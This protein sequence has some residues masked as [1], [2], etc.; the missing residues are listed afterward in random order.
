MSNLAGGGSNERDALYPPA[1]LISDGRL[2]SNQ[3]VAFAHR[4]LS[5]APSGQPPGSFSTELKS[6]VTPRTAG[7]R[8]DGSIVGGFDFADEDGRIVSE[9]RQADFRERINKEQK[10]KIGS[11]NLLEALVSKSA[12]QTKEQRSKV[13]S[14][15]NSSNRKI[16]QLRLQLEEEIERSKGPSTPSRNRLSG[17]FRPNVSRSPTH[18]QIAPS[19]DPAAETETESP[20]LVLA[21]ILQ[22]LETQGMQPDYYVERANSLVELFKRHATLKYDL[23]WSIF[24]LR[25]QTMLL[26]DSREVVAAGY[27]VTR[28]AITDRKSLN[29]M[30]GL[31][32]DYLVVLSLVKEG[33]ASVEREQALKFVRA[34]IDV[35]EGVKEISRAVVRT[36]VSVAENNEDRLKSMCILTL[37]EILIRD[38][39]LL[40][41]AGGVG[42][43]TEAL[44]DGTYA[45]SESLVAAF[46]YLLDMPSTRKYLSSGHELEIIFSSFTDPLSTEGQE[47]KLKANAKVIASIL[48]TWPGLMALS[49]QDFTAITS[50]LSSLYF[51]NPSM[52]DLILEL[53]FEILRIKPPSWSSSFLAGRRLTTYGRVASLKTETPTN[54]ITQHSEDGSSQRSLVDHFTALLLAVLIKSGLLKALLYILQNTEDGALKRKAT[55]LL[56]EVLK[57]ANALLPSD[58]SADLQA[59]PVLFLSASNFSAEHRFLATNAVYQVDSVNRTLYRSSST[60]ALP[61]IKPIEESEQIGQ[62]RETDQAKAKANALVD[63]AQFRSLLLESQVL[64]SINHTK[65]KWDLIQ[66]IIEGPLLNPKRLDEAIKATKFVKRLVGFYRPFKYRFSDIRN[67]K[68][69]RRYVK[70]GCAL[71]STLLQNPEGVKY[72]AENKLLR[73]IA[74]CLAQLDRMSG[75]TSPSPLF[76]RSRLSETLTGGYF[77]ILGVL[78]SDPKGLLM[79][80]RWRMINMFY[81]IIEL[82]DRDD[83]VKTLLSNMDFALY[84]KSPEPYP[85]FL[86]GSSHSHLRVMLSKALT[87]CPKSIRIHATRLLRKYAVGDIQKAQKTGTGAANAEWAIRLLVTQ[88]YDPEVEVC[89]VAVKILEESCNRKHSLEYVVRCRP[90]LDHLGEIGAPLL[91]RPNEA[92]ENSFLSTSLG[93]HYL[94]GLDYISQEMDDWFLGRNDTYVSLVE[95]SLARAL[96]EQAAKP[97]HS[98]DEA[99][100]RQDYG[101]VPPH[102]YRELTRTAEGCRLLEEKGHFD[103]FVFTIREYGMEQNDAELILKV[104]GCLWA[105]GNVGSMPLSAPFLEKTDVVKW[106]VKIAEES[107]I[108]SMRGTAFYVL[109]LISRSLHGLEILTECGWDVRTTTLGESLG[110]CLPLDLNRLLV[111]KEA[112]IAAGELYDESRTIDTNMVITD[113]DV[114]N[115]KILELVVNLGNTVLTK[116]AAGELLQIKAKKA[117]GFQQPQLFRKVMRILECH[118]FRLQVQRFV[119][120]LFDKSVLRKIVLE[121]EDSED[122]Q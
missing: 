96:T 18:V 31:H 104:K 60:A 40:V 51:P 23:V 39:S 11:E 87:A 19:L 58:W 29:I 34:F 7:L 57:L 6:T 120:D 85:T 30:R 22:A 2:Q 117:V 100:E 35:K 17:L 8:V 45:A 121:E 74:E 76:S 64:N 77:A 16:A 93:Y 69:N 94:D 99:P 102:F 81:H 71:I 116:R 62:T 113:K 26:S 103:D 9:Q 107:E 10:I 109:G 112:R 118:H 65:W 63:E 33:K 79:I 90:A 115:A 48:K 50:L 27:R 21:E 88:L 67:T 98:A 25:M 54:T 122:E 111:V 44:A 3:S 97:R 72:L 47:Q 52:R 82:K 46:L 42:P 68:P 70:I 43:L 59:L 105:V 61:G 13:E 83:L 86:T 91:L 5:L 110:Y 55:L 14:E 20:S 92:N 75:L 15:L 101:I 119:I 38:P 114:V 36:I 4:D 32:T 49:T 12:K 106:L 28:Y 80:E 1:R 84:V 66:F 24:G 37:A 41:S 56:G 73:Q 89:E 95:A 53:L 78:S 108:M